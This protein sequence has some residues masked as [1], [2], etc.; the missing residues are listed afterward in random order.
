MHLARANERHAGQLLC[1]TKQI[2]TN[3]KQLHAR[4]DPQRPDRL[5]PPWTSPV[6]WW[7]QAMT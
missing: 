5:I 7:C 6:M 2:S 3:I 1:L 4:S